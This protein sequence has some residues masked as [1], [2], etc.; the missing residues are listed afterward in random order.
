MEN[1]HWC[2]WK[3]YEFAKEPRT[4][5]SSVAIDGCKAPFE[6]KCRGLINEKNIEYSA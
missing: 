5:V 2:R 6:K 3:N 4:E 1:A